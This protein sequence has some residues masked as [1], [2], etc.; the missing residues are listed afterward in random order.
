MTRREIYVQEIKHIK[1]NKR[2]NER[3]ENGK[4]KMGDTQMNVGEPVRRWIGEIS[5]QRSVFGSELDGRLVQENDDLYVFVALSR[6]YHAWSAMAICPR[7]QATSF[8]TR[9]NFV[10]SVSGVRALAHHPRHNTMRKTPF[11]PPCLK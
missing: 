4:S 6:A 2:T 1:L 5:V 10:K 3:R 7:T 11:G 8:T 9:S